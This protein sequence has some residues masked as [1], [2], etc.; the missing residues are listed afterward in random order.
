M[1]VGPRRHALGAFSFFF[2]LKIKKHLNIIGRFKI[3]H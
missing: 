3:N 1:F 2:A